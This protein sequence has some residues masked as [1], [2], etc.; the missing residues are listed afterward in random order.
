M[1][2]E[3]KKLFASANFTTWVGFVLK[4]NHQNFLQEIMLNE[5]NKI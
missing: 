1:G 2:L 5:F 3:K 4:L